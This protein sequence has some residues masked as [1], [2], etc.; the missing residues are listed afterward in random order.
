[1]WNKISSYE[2]ESHYQKKIGG[3]YESELDS[4]RDLEAMF[5][6]LRDKIL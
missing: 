6:H 1:M 3:L 2:A 5:R 4:V